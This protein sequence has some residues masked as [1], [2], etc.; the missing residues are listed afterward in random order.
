MTTELQTLL[1]DV[2]ES[3]WAPTASERL[4]LA[5]EER[6]VATVPTWFRAALGGDEAAQV[7]RCV[8]WERCTELAA[9]PPNAGLTW[10]YL[11]NAVRWRLKDAVAGTSGLL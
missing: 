4:A 9:A 10:G 11:A 3:G 8:A 6:I 1:A 7:A 2:V 5:I